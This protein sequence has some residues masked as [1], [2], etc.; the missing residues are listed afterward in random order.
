MV[1]APN[2][3]ADAANIEP[4]PHCKLSGARRVSGKFE[5]RVAPLGGYAFWRCSDPTPPEGRSTS[6]PDPAFAAASRL[7]WVL[8]TAMVSVVCYGA[9]E[10]AAQV[11]SEWGLAGI[12]ALHEHVGVLVIVDVLS[13]ST[14]VDVA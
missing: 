13:F 11:L 2:R 5:E 4:A 3:T 12:A 8:P 7:T 9:S 14:A 1:S 6:H 10:V